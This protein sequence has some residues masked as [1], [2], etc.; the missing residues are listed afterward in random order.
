GKGFL[1]LRASDGAYSGLSLSPIEGAELRPYNINRFD[2]LMGDF[3][4]NGL[5]EGGGEHQAFENHFT[6]SGFK[7]G[8]EYDIYYYGSAYP[9]PNARGAEVTLTGGDGP[10]MQEIR[11]LRPENKHYKEGITHTLF[12]GVAPREDGT[13]DI[14]WKSF[15][16][17]K[18]GNFGILNGLTIVAPADAEGRD[19]EIADRMLDGMS[20]SPAMS[21]LQ[22]ERIEKLI[23][24]FPAPVVEKGKPLVEKLRVSNEDQAKHLAEL[25]P[26]IGSGDPQRGKEVFF[27]NKAACHTCHRAHGEGGEVGP[28]LTLIGRIRTDRDLAESI[29]YPS[30]TIANG[31]TTFSVITGSG[32]VVDGVIH[33]E[34]ADAIHLRMADKPEEKIA[35][36]D[37]EEMIALPTSIMPQGLEKTISRSELSDLIAYL[38]TLK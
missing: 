1:Y 6:I 21:S 20:E 8:V 15:R 9:K 36:E 31:Y 29:V 13:I 24:R 28:E 32:R 17:D 3:V 7:P 11:G 16:D 2:R 26:H 19:P 22:P 35:R 34:T 12:E 4:Y 10:V 33:R 38:R 37:I 5:E 18:E 27:G 30:S 14:S 25:M 23:S